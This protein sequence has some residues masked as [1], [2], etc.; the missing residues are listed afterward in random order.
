MRRN[1]FCIQGE[2]RCKMITYIF[3]GGYAGPDDMLTQ[4]IRWTM[5]EMYE[6]CDDEGLLSLFQRYTTLGVSG[7]QI[8]DEVKAQMAVHEM[9]EDL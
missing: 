5:N 7:K 1:T 4:P 3:Q 2:L 6:L 9:L 8:E